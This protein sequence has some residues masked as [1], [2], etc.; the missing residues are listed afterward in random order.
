M[1]HQMK[2][3]K[4]KDFSDIILATCDTNGNFSAYLKNKTVPKNLFD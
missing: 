1:E 3:Q 4:I 2:E